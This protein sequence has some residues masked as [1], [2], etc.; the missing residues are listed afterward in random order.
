M[1]R[2]KTGHWVEKKTDLGLKLLCG[3]DR[4]FLPAASI[5]IRL[6]FWVCFPMEGGEGRS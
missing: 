4:S 2:N 5:W 1:R 6:D 3:K